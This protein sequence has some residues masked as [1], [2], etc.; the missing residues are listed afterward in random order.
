[1]K[2]YNYRNFSVSIES[3]YI[4]IKVFYNLNEKDFILEEFIKLNIN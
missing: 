4:N 3:Q 2:S 1:M